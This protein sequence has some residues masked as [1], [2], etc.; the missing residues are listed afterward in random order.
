MTRSGRERAGETV[1]VPMPG[2]CALVRVVVER[3]ASAPVYV[4]R[5]WAAPRR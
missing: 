4:D 3:S 1:R 2:R 5:P